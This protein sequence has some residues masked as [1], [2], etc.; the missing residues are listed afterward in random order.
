MDMGKLVQPI[1]CGGGLFQIFFMAVTLLALVLEPVV[2]TCQG[3]T[4]AGIRT[5]LE[6]KSGRMVYYRKF[7]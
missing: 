1:F 2:L 3:W 5:H 4:Y 7:S 6:V